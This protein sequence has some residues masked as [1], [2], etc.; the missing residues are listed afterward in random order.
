[1]KKTS[2]KDKLFLHG[3]E[4]LMLVAGAGILISVPLVMHSDFWTLWF[5]AKVVYLIGVVGMLSNK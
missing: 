3:S 2:Q 1:M 5:F 4:I